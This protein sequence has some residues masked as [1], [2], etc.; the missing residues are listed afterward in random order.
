[1]STQTPPATYLGRGREGSPTSIVGGLGVS[2]FVHISI[3]V[4]I[5]IGSI[6]GA[7]AI[8]EKAE[9]KLA[10]FTP[11]ELIR[12]GKPREKKFLP[13]IAN[14]A[15]KQVEEKV[16]N[17]AKKP[18]PDKVVI[19][20]EEPPKD[21]EVVK[22]KKPSAADILHTL[23]NPNRPVNDDTPEGR[24]FGVAEGNVVDDSVQNLMNTYIAQVQRAVLREWRVPQTISESRAKD[25]ANKVRVQVRVSDDGY[26]T[27]YSFLA[28]SGDSQFDASIE[29]A[30]RRF[31]VRFGG[32][33][34]PQPDRD[35]VGRVVVQKGL[36]LG[37]WR[38]HF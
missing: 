17:L 28:R 9:E 27:S 2:F 18:D 7:K 4:A 26:I 32:R 31:M 19:K 38:P 15:P 25:M 10:P 22:Q 36:I 34:L 6:T 23:H 14:P 5:I 13:R 16:V 24:E 1:M 30:V 3:V 12:L 20:K 8:E 21:A 11:V 35:D 33:K 37:R 29:E